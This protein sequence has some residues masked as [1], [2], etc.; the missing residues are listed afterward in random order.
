MIFMACSIFQMDLVRFLCK[1][2][3]IRRL[4]TIVLSQVRRCAEQKVR[5]VHETKPLRIQNEALFA[6]PVPDINVVK[7]EFVLFFVSL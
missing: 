5:F 3:R 7:I 2:L 6:H 4:Q 1:L